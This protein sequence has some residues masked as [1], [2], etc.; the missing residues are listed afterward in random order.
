MT[1]RD[2]FDG[3][4]VRAMPDLAFTG[5]D[6]LAAR[7]PR[8]QARSAAR[9]KAPAKSGK[10]RL[11]AVTSGRRREVVVGGRR[12]KTIDVHAH[13]VIP[14]AY[15][16]LGLEGAGASRSRASTRSG[17]ERIAEMDAQGIDI[18]ALSINPFWY[19]AERDVADRGRQDPERAA[20]RVLREVSGSLRRVRLASRCSS[21]ISPCSSSS[22]G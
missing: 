1:T 11:A 20:R 10:P 6:L 7:T 4:T 17:R 21:R 19:R 9:G 5:C 14:E 8:A 22:T 16:L 13:C 15:A 18:E 2:A 12:V 3:N